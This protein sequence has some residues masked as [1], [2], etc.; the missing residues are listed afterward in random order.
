MKPAT[1]DPDPD[2]GGRDGSPGYGATG[3]AGI[4]T[5]FEPT[6]SEPTGSGAHR[7]QRTGTTTST[8][9]FKH[10]QAG[11]SDPAPGTVNVGDDELDHLLGISTGAGGGAGSGGA[12]R[13]SSATAA[14]RTDDD[15]AFLDELLG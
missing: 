7:L 3:S 2:P 5:G 12:G 8:R 11:P 1:K 6:G 4:H 10:P 9:S 14:A 13:G 15:D